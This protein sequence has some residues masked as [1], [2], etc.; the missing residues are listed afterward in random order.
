MN[1]LFV[2]VVAFLDIDLALVFVPTL[3]L[4]C[5]YFVH[6]RVL[7]VLDVALGLDICSYYRVSSCFLLYFFA[8]ITVAGDGSP[9]RRG[10]DGPVLR[11]KEGRR[12]CASFPR[13]LRGGGIRAADGLPLGAGGAGADRA[14]RALEG[15]PR[16]IPRG[17]GREWIR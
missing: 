13:R 14:V 1:K 11:R 3:N 8:G 17:G 2:R 15:R 10:H 6:I 4:V 9:Q 5:V 12:R 16:G 7:L